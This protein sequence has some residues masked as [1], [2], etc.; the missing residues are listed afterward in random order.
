[1]NR[2]RQTK[3]WIGACEISQE[4]NISIENQERTYREL[5]ENNYYWKSDYQKWI[6]D[7]TNPDPATQLIKIRVGAEHSKVEGVAYQLRIGLEEQGYIFIEKS[8]PYKCRPPK[9]LESRIYLT[10]R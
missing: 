10:F 8:E 3:K 2:F 9:Q 7:E 1:M 4:L 5:N 6:L